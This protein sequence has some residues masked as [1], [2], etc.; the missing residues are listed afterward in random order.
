[1]TKDN[2]V[3]I[4]PESEQNIKYYDLLIPVGFRIFVQGRKHNWNN[5]QS[6]ITDK[7]Q[8]ILIIPVVKSSFSNLENKNSIRIITVL[9]QVKIKRGKYFFLNIL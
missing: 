3:S 2:I 1:M 7:R 4:S 5:S 9:N 8:N 6:I